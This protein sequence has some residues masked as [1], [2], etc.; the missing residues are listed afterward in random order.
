MA[1]TLTHRSGAQTFFGDGKDIDALVNELADAPDAEHPEVSVAHDSGWTLSA[2]TTGRLVWENVELD[3]Q[4]RH[5]LAAGPEEIRRLFGLVA[6]GLI[7]E[8][9]NWDWKPGYGVRRSLLSPYEFTAEPWD[10]ILATYT[11]AAEDDRSLTHLVAIAESVVASPSSNLLAGRISSHVYDLNVAAVPIG[12]PPTETIIVRTPRS[13]RHPSVPG[14]V[15]I[16]HAT[17]TG[18]DD[19]VERPAGEAVALFWR[20]VLEKFGVPSR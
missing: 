19:R 17:F 14:S 3:D 13:L 15:I 11:E 6:R 1:A 16:E 12:D 8:V 2:F 7:A 5:A 10:H 18:R 20:F 4:P 9:D